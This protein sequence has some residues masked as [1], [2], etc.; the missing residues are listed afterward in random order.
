MQVLNAMVSLE[1]FK[2]LKHVTSF[3]NASNVSLMLYIVGKQVYQWYMGRRTVFGKLT[4]RIVFLEIESLS[5]C[6][7]NTHIP[8]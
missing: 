7:P 1:M 6:S 4:A 8:S 3:D 2:C 5:S